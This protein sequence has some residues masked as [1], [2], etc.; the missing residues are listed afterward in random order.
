MPKTKEQPK[1]KTTTEHRHLK[2]DLTKEE[3]LVAGEK[4]ATMLDD[5][6]TIQAEKDSVSKEFKAREA[7]IDA[8]I[9]VGQLLV[10]NKWEHRKVECSNVL[11]YNLMECI[12]TRKDTGAEV[13]RR[14][15]TEDEKQSTLPFD[16]E[17]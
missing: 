14:K 13:M 6:K 10:R 17:D 7:A 16:G 15:L 2:C 9:Q 12:V 4:L 11:D 8:E 3:L 1:T 5:L